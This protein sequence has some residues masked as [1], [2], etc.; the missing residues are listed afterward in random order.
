MAHKSNDKPDEIQPV[1]KRLALAMREEI[2]ADYSFA[3]LVF[4]P[5]D[6]AGRLNY[7]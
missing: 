3:I 5:G 7:I 2:P 1:L 4:N 6:K